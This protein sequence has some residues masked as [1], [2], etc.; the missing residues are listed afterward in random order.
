[1]TIEPGSKD[2]ENAEI[3]AE[4]A[5]PGNVESPQSQPIA[6]IAPIEASVSNRRGGGKF[7]LY[8]ALV[9]VVL[10]FVGAL[11]VGWGLW[12]Y[13]MGLSLIYVGLAGAVSAVVIGAAL[14]WSQRRKQVKAPF[15]LRWLGMITGAGLT[16]YLLSW[17]FVA[18]TTPAIHDIST[19]LA[20]PPQFAELTVRSDN[21]DQIPGQGEDGMNGMS[22]RQRW[23]VVH[24]REYGN[25][26]AV[27]INAPVDT[28]IAKAER[29]AHA[30]GWDVASVS[31][32]DGRLEAT[33]VVTLFRFKDNVVLRVRPTEDGM[34]SRVDMRSIN[35]IDMSDLG[36]NAERI[37]S[38]LADLSGTVS[39]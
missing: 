33:D 30:R 22:P 38:F 10:A 18:E 25:I 1:M 11:G 17:G 13:A 32:E 8:L 34:G 7:V 29:L 39:S 5:P 12:H 28:V 26:R 3:I 19:D 27:R 24:Q 20:E 14:G 6:D 15:F 31:P 36:R 35:R 21:F 16:G 37:Q 9:S 4:N 2:A 23:A